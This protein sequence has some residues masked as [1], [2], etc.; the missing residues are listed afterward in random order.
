MMPCYT[1]E[2]EPQCVHCGC[3]DITWVDDPAPD[4]CADCAARGLWSAMWGPTRA[5]EYKALVLRLQ[6]RLKS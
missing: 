3:T 1:P 4:L 5:D 6:Q 2:D